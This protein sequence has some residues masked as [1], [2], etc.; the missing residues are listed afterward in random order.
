MSNRDLAS[1]KETRRFPF[2]R[3]FENSL[4]ITVL[5]LVSLLVAVIVFYF[6]DLQ[7]LVAEAWKNQG[8]IVIVL[9]LSLVMFV[10]YRKR[11]MISAVALSSSVAPIDSQS[12]LS[13]GAGL[14]IVVFALYFCGSQTSFSLLVHLGTLPLFVAAAVLVLFNVQTL[15]Q[16]LF[17]VVALFFLISPA[18]LFSVVGQSMIDVYGQ[19]LSSIVL[20]VLLLMVVLKVRFFSGVLKR[21]RSE[22]SSW[23]IFNVHFRTF[24]WT[25]VQRSHVRRK[26]IN[27]S[28]ISLVIVL[29]FVRCF[30]FCVFS[31]CGFSTFSCP[32]WRI[33][34]ED[35]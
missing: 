19:I 35:R 32:F 30:L 16:V 1:K 6:S 18:L 8:F 31:F 24:G 17:P 4:F 11:R 29:Y 34:L 14:G 20:L 5:K 3:V 21:T 9:V 22:D 13:Y 2:L 23:A 26:V 25:P 10:V 33:R 28:T 12:T 15:R 7:I 27:I